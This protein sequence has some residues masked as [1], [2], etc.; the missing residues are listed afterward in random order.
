M[1]SG[2]LPTCCGS[3]H[4]GV[5]PT[6]PVRCVTCSACCIEGSILFLISDF[7]APEF[8]LPLAAA[9][10]RHDV[11]A[12]SVT[13][14][15]DDELPAEGLLRVVDVETGIRRLLDADD[16]GVRKA[17][18]KHAAEARA[19]LTQALTAAGVD[20]LAVA[21]GTAPVHAL[22]GFFHRRAQRRGR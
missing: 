17:H 8:R 7:I 21:T 6:S 5:A 16:V 11:V 22:T 15:T 1:R 18:R 2:S 9:A 13:D 12:V 4:R 3:R 14:P 20:H 19:K 10:R